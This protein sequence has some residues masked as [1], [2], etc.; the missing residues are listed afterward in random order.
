M[1]LSSIRE[2][3]AGYDCIVYDDGSTNPNTVTTLKNNSDLFKELFL[4]S[5]EKKTSSR[6]RLH[7]NIQSSYEYALEKGYKYLFFVQDD[8]QFVRPLN[9]LVLNEYSQYFDADENIIQV[10]PR[11]LRRL[12]AIKINNELHAYSFEDDDDRGS[13]ADVGILNVERLNSLN[14]S[15]EP[16]ERKNKVKAHNMGLKRIFPFTPI[17]MHLPY[18]VIYRKGKKKNKFPYPFVKRGHVFYKPLS[19]KEI[20]EMDNRDLTVIPYARDL[21]TPKGLNLAFLHYKYAN[22][23]KIFS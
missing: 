7:Q 19:E 16:S 11:F 2:F 9:E 15:F 8:M 5:K 22:E 21:L 23:G 17:F 6:G 10:D 4:L 14:W 1:L 13:Y 12:G 3:A 18:P 20:Q